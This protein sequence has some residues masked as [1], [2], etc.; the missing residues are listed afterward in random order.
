MN[1]RICDDL[2]GRQQWHCIICHPVPITLDHLSRF[3]VLPNPLQ[4]ILQ[5]HWQRPREITTIN[6]PH[7]I[8]TFDRSRN[9]EVRQKT[10]RVLTQSVEAGNRQLSTLTV[11]NDAREVKDRFI[12]VIDEAWGGFADRG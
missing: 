1:Q 4:D 12:T 9:G 6:G 10:L 3:H 11:G 8:G 5:D 7:I 2:T